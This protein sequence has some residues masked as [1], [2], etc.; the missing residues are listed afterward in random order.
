MP[1]VEVCLSPDLLHLHPVEG[2]TV[3]V[4][5][6]LRATSCITAGI[7]SGV[8]S[9]TP[10]A[11]LEECRAL[12]DSGYVGAAERGG[13]QAEG[14]DMGNSPFSFMA[15]DLQGRKVAMTTTNGTLAITKSR[16]SEQILI[17]SFLNLSFLADF[18]RPE[19]RDLIILCAGWKG[20]FSLEDTLFAG[21]LVHK[22][23][24]EYDYE[25][26]SALGAERLYQGAENDLFAYL[27]GSSHFNRL[28]KLNIVR[29]IE[30]CLT[31]EQFEVIPVLEGEELVKL[32]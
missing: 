17:G 31:P 28:S 30:Y 22:L 16:T 5:D 26:D 23:R 7:G 9:I 19:S 15:T 6:V 8:Q 14:F 29:D 27:S 25:D 32:G 24:P 13:K 20:R 3:V 2:K 11:T 10:V 18:L 4:V 12:Q 1:R 21:A